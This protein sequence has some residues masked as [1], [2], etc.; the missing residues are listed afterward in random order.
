MNPNIKNTI[1][2]PKINTI[3]HKEK[4]E[5]KY[6]KDEI[7]NIENPKIDLNSNVK[8]INQEVKKLPYTKHIPSDHKKPK[9]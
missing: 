4:D 1:Q 7:K 3:I 5:H 8:S 2:K 6:R 9:Y